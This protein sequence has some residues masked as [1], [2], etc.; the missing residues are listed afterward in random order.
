MSGLSRR[1]FIKSSAI[2][3]AGT[4]LASNTMLAA[5]ELLLKSKVNKNTSLGE[6]VFVLHSFPTRRSS[7]LNLSAELP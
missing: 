5:P 6:I 3:G 1:K 7:D 4:F 2:A